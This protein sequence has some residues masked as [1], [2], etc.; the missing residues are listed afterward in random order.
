MLYRWQHP[1]GLLPWPY[2]CIVNI[3][4]TIFIYLQLKLYIVYSKY[5]YIFS[6]DSLAL[7]PY[8]DRYGNKPSLI[9]SFLALFPSYSFRFIMCIIYF[10]YIYVISY[11]LC[12]TVICGKNV[13]ELCD[14]IKSKSINQS[15]Y[16]NLQYH[17]S[18]I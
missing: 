14:K 12:H 15:K 10:N 6:T 11:I 16:N 4:G 8:W 2:T 5:L 3:I 18:R 9:A 17:V 13:P 1:I 7:L